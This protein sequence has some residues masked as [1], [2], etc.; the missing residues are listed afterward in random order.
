M[1]ICP[2]TPSMT[3]EQAESQL[4]CQRRPC[5]VWDRRVLFGLIFRS[6]SGLF[7]CQDEVRRWVCALPVLAFATADP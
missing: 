1:L 6:R 4:A 3:D 7:G 2:S 5:A